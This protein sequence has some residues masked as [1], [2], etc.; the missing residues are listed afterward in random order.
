LTH[1][2]F[3]AD[4]MAEYLEIP[5]H[6]LHQVPLGID[7]DGFAP[8]S[9]PAEHPPGGGTI[10]YLARLAPEKGLHLLVDAFLRLKQRAPDRP[11]RLHIAGYL[12][13]MHRPYAQEQFARLRK[14]GY[15]RD[16]VYVG[17]IDRRQK[18]DFL[19]SLDVLSVPTT[20]RDPKGLFVLEALASGVP[21]VQPSHGA[22]PELLQ[23]VGGGVLV[24]PHSAEALAEGLAELLADP[25]RCRQLGQRGREAV[26]RSHHAAAMAAGTW[27][28]WQQF[29][30]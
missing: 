7:V 2:R 29:L 21:V 17:S 28:M 15:E 30:P 4:F 22:F 11:Y 19:R 27:S 1:S 12:G 14:A 24:A 6:Q 10:G 20:Y 8:R 5:R 3:Y 23:Q 9:A 26:L 18:A 25:V 16:F 13:N